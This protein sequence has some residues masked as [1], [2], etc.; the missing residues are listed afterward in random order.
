MSGDSGAVLGDIAG[1]CDPADPGRGR[2][3]CALGEPDAAAR[4]GGD[5][6]WS[7][8][9]C[10]TVEL[11]DRAVVVIRPIMLRAVSANQRFRS[12]PTAMSSGLLFAVG[13]RVFADPVRWLSKTTCARPATRLDSGPRRAR[14]SA[15]RGRRRSR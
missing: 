7:T 5:R 4:A 2:G 1:W 8:C 3:N 13:G 15:S 9:G 11:V 12:G 14:S 10:K 6:S